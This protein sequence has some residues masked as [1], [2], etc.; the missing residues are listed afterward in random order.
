[1]EKGN[2]LWVN[3][4]RPHKIDDCILPADLKKTFAAF[5]DKNHVPNMTLAGGPGMG[6]TTVA[7]ALCEELDVD[8]YKINCSENGNIDTLRTDIRQFASTVS[9]TGGRKAVIMDE[10]D[11]LTKV[12]QQALRPFIEEFG[13]NCSFILTCNYPNQIIEAIRDSRCPTIQFKPTKEDK[14]PMLIG[15]HKMVVGILKKESVKFDNEVLGKV[16]GKYFPDFRAT[17]G[18]LQKY[19]QIGEINDGILSYLVEFPVKALIEAMKDKNF[20]DVRKWVSANIGN[21]PQALY[22]QLF[23]GMHNHFPAPFLPQFIL[24]LAD[25]M[26]QASRSLDQEITLLA[27]LTRVMADEEFQVK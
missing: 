7:M 15:F 27:F 24:I 14:K 13:N 11:G 22:R 2:Q 26:D 25:Y 5:R 18:Q 3:K 8:W 16:I 23:D 17:L 20:T 9:M 12:T 21:E 19:A 4:Y 1:M 6:K 10:A